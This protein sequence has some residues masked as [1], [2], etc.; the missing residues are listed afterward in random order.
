M[1]KLIDFAIANMV[2]AFFIVI[3]SVYSF[4]Q[5]N[6]VLVTNAEGSGIGGVLVFIFEK[7]ENS[8]TCFDGGC[9]M[10]IPFDANETDKNGQAKFGEKGD[11]QPKP[12]TTYFASIDAKCTK[13][14]NQQQPCDNQTNLC[15]Y[16]ATYMEVKTDKKGKFKVVKFIK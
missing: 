13:T 15:K 10:T 7:K 4:G 16:S 5:S 12:N 9:I 6:T 2:I 8:C 1:K 3:C 14:Q 11:P